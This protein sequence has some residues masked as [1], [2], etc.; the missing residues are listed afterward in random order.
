VIVVSIGKP[1]GSGGT[2]SLGGDGGVV[3]PSYFLLPRLVG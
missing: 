1:G 2:K 3:V